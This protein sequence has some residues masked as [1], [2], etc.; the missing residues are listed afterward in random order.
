MLCWPYLR[1]NTRPHQLAVL[2]C[3]DILVSLMWFLAF[4]GDTVWWSGRQ[5]RILR[6]GEMTDL[7][8]GAPEVESSQPHRIPA[9][10]EQEM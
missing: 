2:W 3:K 7:T 6:N 1:S 9:I 10:P 8:P 4:A 5:F